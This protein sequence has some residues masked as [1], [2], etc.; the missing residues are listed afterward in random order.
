MDINNLLPWLQG[1]RKNDY[2]HFFYNIEP[3]GHIIPVDAASAL[4]QCATKHAA[5]FL[6]DNHIPALT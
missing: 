1:D 2:H 6:Q 5:D 3:Q 4:F